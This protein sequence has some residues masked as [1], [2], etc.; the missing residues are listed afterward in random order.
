MVRFRVPLS[1][2]ALIFGF[3]LGGVCEELSPRVF[4]LELKPI[5]V[6]AVAL[7][8]GEIL[9]TTS[10]LVGK[11]VNNMVVSPDGR[12][13]MILDKGKG[14]QTVRFGYHPKEKSWITFID[15]TTLEVVARTEVGWSMSTGYLWDHQGYAGDWV[16]SP[17]GRY[18]TIACFGYRS[19]K[20]KET[21]P[22]ELVTLNLD[23]GEVARRL[24]LERPI[25]SLIATTVVPW[26]ASRGRPPAPVRCSSTTPITSSTASFCID[27]RLRRPRRSFIRCHPRPAPSGK[28]RPRRSS[29]RFR[30]SFSSW[31]WRIWSYRKPSL[32]RESR[33]LRPC[34]PM[35][36][37]FTC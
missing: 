15:A 12:R 17:D 28:E 32:S 31:T 24:I 22:A 20:S 1:L 6:S 21:L 19:Q 8:S 14:K 18:M 16:F 11:R 13:I 35:E 26:P 25:D 33:F 2:C 10:P 9:G 5:S 3:A 36:A 34:R 30:Q 23:N 4:V 7:E 27:T 29:R 37:I